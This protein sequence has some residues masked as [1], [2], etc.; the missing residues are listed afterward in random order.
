MCRSNAAK[1]NLH[2]KDV[3]FAGLLE[4]ERERE[5]NRNLVLKFAV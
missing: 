2:F 3:R 4:R 5:S 1:N